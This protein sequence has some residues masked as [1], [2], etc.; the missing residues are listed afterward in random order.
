MAA[1]RGY[2]AAS[3][4]RR[5]KRFSRLAS[6]QIWGLFSTRTTSVNIEMNRDGSGKLWIERDRTA[7]HSFKWGPDLEPEGSK[8][9]ESVEGKGLSNS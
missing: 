2:I 3:D 5:T 4:Y 9:E 7:V 8:D 6:R 1:L